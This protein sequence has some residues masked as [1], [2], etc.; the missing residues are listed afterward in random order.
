MQEHL[1]KEEEM[2]AKRYRFADAPMFSWVLTHDEGLCADVI[3][4]ILGM[5]IEGIEAS[6]PEA[7]EIPLPASHGVRFD[8]K[9][10]N[11]EAVFDVEMQIAARPDLARR[12]RYYQAA[13][14]VTELRRSKSYRLLPESY[15]IFICVGDF[16]KE[17]LGRRSF[18]M[19]DELG[20]EL[21]DGRTA[22]FLSARNYGT[23]EDEGLSRLLRYVLDGHVGQDPLAARIQAA[24]DMANDDEEAIMYMS[25]KDELVSLQEDFQNLADEADAMRGEIE[26]KCA[27][28]EAMDA[29]LESK[30][31]EIEA[32]DAE[33]ERLKA[34]LAA[35]RA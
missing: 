8:V 6:E 11:R 12:A 18:K 27:E 22:I 2:A 20:A 19:R 32:K 28:V 14:D 35:A 33:I 3:G 26:S 13:M 25:D 16:F 10:R 1:G 21:R 29:E 4:T 31:A 9:A 7:S 5:P 34:E 15:V 24:V 30:R 23:I 17:G